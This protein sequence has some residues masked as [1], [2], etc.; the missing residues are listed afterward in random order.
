MRSR[1]IQYVECGQYS[2]EEGASRL[3]LRVED[4]LILALA[5]LAISSKLST[6]HTTIMR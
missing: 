4:F 1:Y 5:A 2:E 6:F 3:N